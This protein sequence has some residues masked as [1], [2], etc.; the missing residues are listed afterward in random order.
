M[1]ELAHESVMGPLRGRQT[2]L[3]EGERAEDGESD[4]GEDEGAVHEKEGRL[5]DESELV[6]RTS[7]YNK[8]SIFSN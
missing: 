5:A 8:F 6:P 1:E 2:E 3:V 7:V 4:N